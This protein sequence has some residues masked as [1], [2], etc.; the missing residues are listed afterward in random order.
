[1]S[2]LE[3]ALAKAKQLANYDDLTGL[4]NRRLMLDRFMQAAAL[5]DRHRQ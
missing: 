1:M 4:P 2:S 3:F 5:A